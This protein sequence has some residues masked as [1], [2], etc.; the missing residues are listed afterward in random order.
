MNETHSTD[1]PLRSEAAG[2]AQ[3]PAG[4]SRLT[5]LVLAL[6]LVVL[7]VAGFF[8]GYLPRQRRESVLAAESKIA[9]DSLPVVNVQKVRRADAKT[10]LVLRA[11]SRP[12][13]EAPILARANGYIKRR[14]GRYRRPGERGA[15]SGRN[16]CS[17]T[18]P[19]ILQ[20][21]ATVDQA[22]STVEQAQAALQQGHSNENLAR[23][24][25]QRWRTCPRRAWFRARRTTPTRRN[26]LPNRP[27]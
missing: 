25:A 3:K 9:E 24:T 20:A 14:Y 8:A 17:R 11:T 6:L 16:R 2:S 22:N 19:A 5:L 15:G 26:G 4:P 23:V 1:D 10:S 21:K 13:T 27:T 7:V 18:Q 12:V